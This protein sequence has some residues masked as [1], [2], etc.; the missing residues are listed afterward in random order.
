MDKIM[1]HPQARPSTGLTFC[2]AG[3]VEV[4]AAARTS[5]AAGWGRGRHPS[6]PFLDR[7]TPRRINQQARHAGAGLEQAG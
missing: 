3:E 2:S 4:A 5:T 6:D 1:M 7:L